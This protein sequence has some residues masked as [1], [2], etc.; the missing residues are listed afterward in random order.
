MESETRNCQNCKKDFIIDS[1]DFNFYEKIKVPPPTFCPECR[2]IRRMLWRNFRFL[3]KRICGLCNKKIISMYPEDKVKIVYCTDCW[4]SDKRNPLLEGRDYDFSKSFF[5][6][7]YELQKETPL[8]FIYHSGFLLRSEYTNYSVDNK[9]CY[10]SF[11]IVGCENVLYSEIID[12]S[13]NSLDCYGGEKL[14]GC[15]FNIDCE[16]NYNT[17]YAINSNKCI[18]S[19]FI[20]DCSNCQ[21]CFLSSNLRNQ[22][23]VFKNKKLTKEEYKKEILKFQVNTYSGFNKCNKLFDRMVKDNSIHKYA[24]IVNS[25]NATGDYILN[26]KNIINSFDIKDSENIKN[27]SRVLMNSK[28]CL[29][30]CGIASGELN[31]ECTVCSFNTFKNFFCY[32]CLG[33]RESEYCLNSRNISNCFGCIGLTNAQYCIFNKQYRKEEYFKI[34]EKI[35]KQMMELPYISTRKNPST[36]LGQVYKY[37]EFFPIELSPFAYNTC[38]VK[39]LLPAKKNEVLNMGYDWEEREKREYNITL[40]SSEIKDDISNIDDSFIEEI[41]AC[42]NKGDQNYDCSTGYKILPFELQF[43][44]K[45]KLPIPRYCPNCRYEQR[46]KYRNPVRLY[47][48]KC[49]KE[50]CTNEF[51]TSYAP[52]RPETIYCERCYQQEV[53]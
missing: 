22:Q 6:Q 31:Y 33:S 51:K 48:R 52:E 53:Y 10:L 8:L 28:D 45:N 36:G 19:M 16:S 50:G 21:N 34:I 7:F 15:F 35:K 23:Y 47:L 4:N 9:D 40:D 44:K 26:S 13:K 38:T 37:G 11:S 18:D 25:T 14:E 29:D 46:L 5:E 20:F 41:I 3:S 27:S 2:L 12:N 42:P 1:E 32:I 24:H 30:C 39:S 49:M 17:H 43:Y